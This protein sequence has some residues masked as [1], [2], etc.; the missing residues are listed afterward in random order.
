MSNLPDL[1][2][3]PLAVAVDGPE[4]VRRWL[5]SLT[6]NTARGYIADLRK[7]AEHM[8]TPSSADAILK[9]CLMSNVEAL[10]AIEAWRDDMKAD[11]LSPATINRRLS[12]VNACF[13]HLKR[14][15]I[16][17]GQVDVDQVK[18]E[19]RREVEAAKPDDIATVLQKLE[20]SGRPTDLRNIAIIMIAAQRGLRRSEIAALMV[21]DI[22]VRASRMKVKRKGKAEKLSLVLGAST[23][24][25]I[26]RWIAVRPADAGTLFG[27]TAD[28]IY[29][30]LQSTGGWHPHQ[31]RHTAIEET[32]RNTGNNLPLAQALAGHSSPSTTMIYI[33]RK[34]RA[35]LE[36]QAVAA[37]E[38]SYGVSQA[39]KEDQ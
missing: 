28:G 33:G 4:R 8:G 13:R 29:A 34:E 21:D 26:E 18:L 25:A 14:A 22:D 2:G 3:Q 7:L 11:G 30:M 31:L 10:M 5:A 17:P 27:I 1:S 35:S 23:L 6:P 39:P 15:G 19:A 38:R 9:I 12:A 36:K 32:L 16:G 24:A 20:A 37:T